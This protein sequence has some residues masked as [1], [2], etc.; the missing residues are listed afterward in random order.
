[1]SVSWVRVI[2]FWMSWRLKSPLVDDTKLDYW[3]RVNWT[4]VGCMR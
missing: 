4:A 1:M 3:R 2:S